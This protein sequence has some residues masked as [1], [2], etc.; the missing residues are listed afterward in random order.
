[1]P[2]GPMTLVAESDPARSIVEA[3]LTL[4]DDAVFARVTDDW[5][6]ETAPAGLARAH[7]VAA[8]VWGRLVVREGSVD[9]I[10]EDEPHETITV[11]AGEAQVIPPQRPHRVVFTGPATFAV[12]FYRAPN[13]ADGPDEGQE[14]TGLTG[15][16]PVGDDA[17]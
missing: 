6:P 7:R 5:T 14:S 12:E 11:P 2:G 17:R 15:G 8:G 1:M 9:F 13:Q 4:P 10:F 16:D 3:M